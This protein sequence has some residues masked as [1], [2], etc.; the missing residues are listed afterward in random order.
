MY[1]DD[2]EEQSIRFE[3]LYLD[4][5]N[6]RFY[7]EK[8][9]KDVPDKK[10]TEE[11]IQARTEVNIRRHGIEELYSNILRN[12]FLPLDRIVVRPIDGF[13]DKYVVVEGNRRLAALRVLRTRIA[14]AEVAEEGLSDEYLE[15]LRA[16]TDELLVLVYRG[17]IGHDISWLL[18]GVRHISGIRPWQ[19]A[20]RA[21]LV[22]DQID[23]RHLGFA[24]AG[25]KFGLTA[26]AVGRL[27]RSYKALEQM[28]QD[29]EFQKKAKNDYFS[30]FEEAYRN[31]PVREWLDWSDDKR[32]YQNTDNLRQFYSWITPD[33]EHEDKRRLND[34]KQIKKLGQL[35]TGQHQKLL[36]QFDD[37][38]VTIDRAQEIAQEEPEDFDWKNAI[39]R[40]ARY[41]AEIP[42]NAIA[43]NSED[44]LQELMG[45]EQSVGKLKK[46]AQAIS[47]MSDEAKG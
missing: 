21:R 47:G 44:V 37:H 6:P 7:T 8:S 22:A 28:R 31:R 41:I 10:I 19:P 3:D 34:V 43:Q 23:G 33:E 32:E 2:L 12:G 25:Q 29:D 13:E 15:K 30:L 4:P 17:D 27:Y 46:M 35:L 20:Q 38:E 9:P 11:R 26:Q 18:Q 45:L 1:A 16:S 24:E 14:D 40:A 5:N 39:K 42:Q 36:G